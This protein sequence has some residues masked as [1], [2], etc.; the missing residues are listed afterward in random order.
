MAT[1]ESRFAAGLLLLNKK[2]ILRGSF[3]F[4]HFA[5]QNDI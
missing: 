5:P 3:R 4:A 1:E 2:E